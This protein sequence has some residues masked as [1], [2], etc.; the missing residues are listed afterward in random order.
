MLDIL[1]RRRALALVMLAVTS[2]SVPARAGTF[3]F[4]VVDLDGNPIGN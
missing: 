2:A 4:A 3:T 1:L